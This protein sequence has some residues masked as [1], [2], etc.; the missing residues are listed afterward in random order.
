MQLKGSAGP[1]KAALGGAKVE[2][3]E[4]RLVPGMS[5]ARS[6]TWRRANGS[7]VTRVYPGVVNVRDGSGGW[8]P[9]DTAL[10]AEGGSLVATDGP[11]DVSLPAKAG[12]LVELDG[13]GDA[14]V[15]LRLRGAAPVAAK[16]DG[17]VATYPEVAAGVDARWSVHPAGAKEDLILRSAGVQRSFTYDLGLSDGLRPST[18][19]DGG[20]DV[21][22][23]GGDVAFSFA[24]PLAADAGGVL[25]AGEDVSMKLSRD[26]AGW[27]ITA[28]LS[29][30]WLKDPSRKF[31]VTLDPSAYSGTNQDCFLDEQD[32]TT[33][34]CGSGEL[35]AGRAGAGHRHTA[36]VSFAF[37]SEVPA[38]AFIQQATVNLY[39]LYQ[40]NPS[41]G[42]KDV[43]IAPVTEDW[44][45]AATWQQRTSAANW[46]T[47]G[48]SAGTVQD[49]RAM[50]AAGA[51]SE[52]TVTDQVSKWVDGTW[53]T[54]TPQVPNRGFAIT[55][56]GAAVNNAVVYA[57]TDHV[58]D[59]K[60]PY[61]E[62]EYYGRT[63]QRGGY[64]IDSQQISARQSVGVNV[65]GGNLLA[66]ATDLDVDG[67][68]IPVT[69]QRFYNSQDPWSG[70]L[71]AKGRLSLGNDLALYECDGRGSRCLVGPSGYRAR[72]IKNTD[73]SFKTPYGAG[74]ITLKRL[75]SGR[76]TLTSNDSGLVYEFYAGG[77]AFADKIRDQYG[78]YLS[79]EF[80]GT[81]GH[82]SKIYDTR[83]RAFPVQT[84]AA[85]FITKISVPTSVIA[86]GAEWNYE[87]GGGDDLLTKV[88][89]PEGRTTQFEY[90]HDVA[91]GNYDL[92]TKIT[93]GRSNQTL[94]TYDADARATS[95]TRRVDGTTANDVKTTYA[96][97]ALA[98][99]TSAG[100]QACPAEAGAAGRTVVTDPRGK[101]TTY[102]WNQNGNVTRAFDHQGRPT[103][104]SWTPEGN[105]S[106]FSSFAGGTSSFLS[107]TEMTYGGSSNQNVTQILEPKGE[108]TTL[109]YAAP[110]GDLI[111]DSR[112]STVT[113]PQSKVTR[114]QYNAAG[115]VTEISDS[116][117][118][119]KLKATLT[120]NANGTTATSKDG[121]NNV[122]TYGYNTKGELTSMTPPAGSGLGATTYTYDGLSRVKTMTDARGNVTTYTYNKLGEVTGVSDQIGQLTTYG[123]DAN[124]NRT[125]RVTGSQTTTYVFDKLGRKTSESF[126]GSITNTYGYDKAG[127]LTSISEP[128]GLTTYTY[129]DLGRLATVVSPTATTGTDSVSYAYTDPATGAEEAKVVQTL[130][131]PT[132]GTITTAADLSGK[133]TT[134]TVKTAGGTQTLKREWQYTTTATGTQQHTLLDA[135]A[136]Y[137][138]ASTTPDRV[139]S[140]AYDQAGQLTGAETL[141]AAG[142]NIRLDELTYD[143]AG[144][145]T[146]RVRT[147][148][149]AAP[150]TMS[151]AYNAANQLCQRVIG[152]T[153][154]CS[155]TPPAGAISYSYD[156][157]GNQLTGDQT[158]TW[159]AKN[160]LASVDG[161]AASLL[162]TN[163][164]ELVGLGTTSFVNNV[165]GISRITTGTDVS[166]LVRSP[167]DGS[168][169]S[170]V[171]GSQKHWFATDHLGSTIALVTATGAIDQRYSYD[172]DGGDT[173][174]N[175]TGPHTA[176][177]Y[178]GGH[179]L[180]GTSGLYH[181]GAR[182]YSPKSGRW[183]QADPLLQPADLGNA[184]R[185]AYAGNNPA[186]YTDP[187]GL[188][189]KKA[190]RNARDGLKLGWKRLK[191]V[192]KETGKGALAGGAVGG[193]CVSVT[194]GGC[195]GGAAAAVVVGTGYGAY[196]GVKKAWDEY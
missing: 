19:P 5:S 141:D 157:A 16:V 142:S 105:A 109:D 18:R 128:G 163:N 135:A 59:S 125:T 68:R 61:L 58:D 79:F 2:R 143:N 103:A 39:P 4:G 36:L 122:T 113:D 55:D 175:P 14:R 82:L 77:Y 21:L 148:G 23:A 133:P 35:W 184:N 53:Q 195:A 13:A 57:S 38:A 43:T 178:A 48:G 88:T 147:D 90:T 154:A 76:Y 86:G 66:S 50:P 146:S 80:A 177:R 123:Y 95:I 161:S 137:D 45:N 190:L 46:T 67:I 111:A 60:W 26:S 11:V 28:A 129:D 140:Y 164:A 170:Q 96:Y 162:T 188:F 116:T 89:D 12:G 121:A 186:N 180:P 56:D 119:P 166:K 3:P 185:Y 31:P 174:A 62:V 69:L 107:N 91:N 167:D 40:T 144:N 104:T 159:D 117:T 102:C 181:Y 30:S 176:I 132:G 83:G 131:G 196:K 149:A 138:G 153:A 120:Y 34:F 112:P 10:K 87:Y 41:A 54:D 156:A 172:I 25:A 139:S 71:G 193:V 74:N 93:D 165:L 32:A 6:R 187:D 179:Q 158:T 171:R 155:G 130:P 97:T 27:T 150:S 152:A 173:P 20:I 7:F 78:N 51:W 49:R 192:G 160:R 37:E 124:G 44:T 191:T 15:S 99:T 98:D 106:K 100:G 72:F 101:K 85:G 75:S 8:R 182:L 29:E 64:T 126:P 114:Y 84:N 145:R 24:A 81:N 115:D 168:V 189:L 73:G 17:P 108:K 183:T 151:Y 47:A 94:I 9:I 42:T 63:G 52:F 127:N 134:V 169:I 136:E 70:L 33:N 194:F 65:A 1:A 92:L 118:S 110:T 22:A